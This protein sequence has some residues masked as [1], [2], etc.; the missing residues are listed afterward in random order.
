VDGEVRTAANKIF[1]DD[2]CARKAQPGNFKGCEVEIVD[3]STL[4]HSVSIELKR[5]AFPLSEEAQALAEEHKVPVHAVPTTN[6]VTYMINAKYATD[7]IMMEKVLK[8]LNPSIVKGDLPTDILVPQTKVVTNDDTLPAIFKL[9]R[10]VA[11]ILLPVFSTMSVGKGKFGVLPGQEDDLTP[12]LDR[13]AK[14]I[15]RPGFRSEMQ[16]ATEK[17][18]ADKAKRYAKKAAA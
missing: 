1:L 17:A 2:G 11:E 7:M 12:A 6:P 9:E 15:N 18:K 14:L 5:Y 16:R 8:A 13:T 3:G 4:T 10:E